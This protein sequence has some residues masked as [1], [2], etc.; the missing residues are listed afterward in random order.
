MVLTKFATGTKMVSVTL[1]AGRAAMRRYLDDSIRTLALN[2]HKMALISGP[3][4]VGKTTLSKSIAKSF[5]Q[6]SYKN[7]DETLFRRL[8]TKS[9]NSVKESFRLE[10][11][12]E[13]KILV[14]DEIH[15]ARGWKQKLKGLYDELN[16]ELAI[17]VTGSARLNVFKKGGDSMLGRYFHFRLHP[18]SYG[19]LTSRNSMD[20]KS[21][22]PESW[23]ASLFQKS[24]QSFNQ[25][26]LEKLLK[27]SG[28][29][30]PFLSGS[31]KTL[32]LW[33]KGRTDKIVREDLR[34]LSRL[35][36]LSRVEMLASLL[37]ERVGSPLSIQSLREDLEVAH[38]TVRRWL[39]Y[40]DE[41]YY[42]FE[43]KPWTR[44]IARSLKKEGKIYLY[45]W[46]EVDE[47]GPRFENLVA[48]HLLKACHFWT[49]TGEGLFD[50]FYLRD[51]E[52]NEI[53]FLIVKDKKPWLCVE[54]KRSD[55]TINH[56]STEKFQRQLGN[57]LFVQVVLE[58]EVWRVE[59]SRAVVS[60]NRFF[61]ALP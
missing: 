9:P 19:E 60:A 43:L 49:D 37:P 51:K 7:W 5:D 40:L 26:P 41:L 42:F 28:F 15:K 58:T 11:S 38:D 29:P 34:D 16:Q 48:C 59:G 53:D 27:L 20:R 57:P 44:S 52:K 8:W 39:N 36:E 18:L 23:R 45:D 1:N 3:R 6:S 30:E 17:I 25:A 56:R 33:R 12:K 4:Q 14:L 54:A 46:T 50:L 32:R 31:E 47:P 35:Q 21:V 61:S 55:T 10:K 13:S 24:A 22:E 2:K